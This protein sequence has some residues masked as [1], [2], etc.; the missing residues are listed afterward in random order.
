MNLYKIELLRFILNFDTKY[1]FEEFGPIINFKLWNINAYS[2]NRINLTM[3]ILHRAFHQRKGW[4]LHCG[5]KEDW[6][7]YEVDGFL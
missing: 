5:A 2:Q 3:C 1:T 4:M 6:V 7:L